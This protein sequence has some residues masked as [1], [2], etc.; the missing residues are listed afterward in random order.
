MGTAAAP[1]HGVL[2][3]SVPSARHPPPRPEFFCMA[4]KD[5]NI[6][7]ESILFAS[8]ARYRRV[9]RRPTWPPLI[10][11]PPLS[12]CWM[13]RFHMWTVG[14]FRLGSKTRIGGALVCTCAGG[15]R[16]LDRFA[17]GAGTALGK[18]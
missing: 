11:Q 5:G 3:A 4:R 12:S 16:K 14:I 10:T 1:G 8:H 6:G 15:G 18:H 7:F 13:V 17:G 2:L 9:P